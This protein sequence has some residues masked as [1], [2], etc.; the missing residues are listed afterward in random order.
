M[1]I[2]MKWDMMSLTL[3]GPDY[4]LKVLHHLFLIRIYR[5]RREGTIP[6]GCL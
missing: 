2:K 4:I 1:V 5:Y 6:Y 3:A